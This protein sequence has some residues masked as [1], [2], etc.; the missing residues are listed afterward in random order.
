MSTPAADQTTIISLTKCQ[1]TAQQVWELQLQHSALAMLPSLLL[2]DL[3]KGSS[4]YVPFDT[5]S[6]LCCT[7]YAWK[8]SF[9]VKS[10]YLVG[11]CFVFFVKWIFVKIGH[12]VTQVQKTSLVT[13]IFRINLNWFQCFFVKSNTDCNNCQINFYLD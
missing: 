12:V 6:S 8:Y 1:K 11:N 13:K 2:V 4:K 9:F 3:K 7:I 5:F 10:K